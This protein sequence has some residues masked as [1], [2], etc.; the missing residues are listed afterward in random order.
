MRVRPDQLDCG[1]KVPNLA[2]AKRSH[3]HKKR[4]GGVLHLLGEQP[5]TRLVSTPS[6]KLDKRRN[7]N[8]RN[9]LCL[10]RDKGSCPVSSTHRN[11]REL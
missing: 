11:V 5:T 7:R 10:G 3:R 1:E 6:G 9:D 2:L 8:E 4:C